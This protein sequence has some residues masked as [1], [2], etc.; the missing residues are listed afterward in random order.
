LLK[1]G[2]VI[3]AK[4]LKLPPKTLAKLKRLK[5]ESET[6]DAYRVAKRL[7]AILLNYAGNTRGKISSLLHTPRACV[8]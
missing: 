3:R 2:K 7:H 6:E 5:K 4:I 8:T 1:K